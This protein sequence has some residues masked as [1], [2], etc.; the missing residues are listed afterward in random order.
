MVLFSGQWKGG[1]VSWLDLCLLKLIQ[2]AWWRI[3]LGRSGVEDSLLSSSSLCFCQ[4]T[5][6]NRSILIFL[7]SMKA[8]LGNYCFVLFIFSGHVSHLYLWLWY[9]R[10]LIQTDLQKPIFPSFLYGISALTNN[11]QSKMHFQFL[12]LTILSTL[13]RMSYKNNKCW[14]SN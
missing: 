4:V 11:A 8:V 10:Q 6:G 5:W 7:N 9:Y 12:E 3:D 2:V 1:W 14:P 13:S